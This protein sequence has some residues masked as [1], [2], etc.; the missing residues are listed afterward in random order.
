MR[1]LEFTRRTDAT[2]HWLKRSIDV[3]N[4]NGSSAYYSLLFRPWRGGWEKAYPE[5][6]GYLIETLLDYEQVSRLP[7]LREYA[8]RC[9]HWLTQ[10]QMESGAMPGGV[11]GSASPSIFNTGQILFGLV[12]A[13]EVTGELV[14]YQ[15]FEKAVRWMCHS[16]EPD[17]SWKTGAYLK[18]YTPSYYTRAVWGVL[19]ANRHLQ[20]SETTDAMLKA[21]NYYQAQITAQ[22]SVHNWGF[23]PGEAAFTH[24][25]AYTIRGFLESAL[26]L[27]NAP[28][29][30]T[31]VQL[32]S[33]VAAVY[34]REGRLAGSYDERWKG[35]Y[36]F[37]CLTGNAQMSIVLARL[38]AETG[39]VYFK[40]I[41][42]RI[43][44]DIKACQRRA[45]VFPNI[46]GAI[47]GSKPY[48]GKYFPFRYPN[49]AAKFYL[50]AY[51]INQS[52]VFR[53]NV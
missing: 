38:F 10:Q 48:W 13:W 51:L 21:L 8:I 42:Q 53:N 19:Y 33:Q 6:T 22:Q 31:A 46:H 30:E 39:R 44:E 37:T 34:E 41:S 3:C 1:D 15:T 7:W 14:F 5:T 35:D 27:K 20:Q 47:P 16:L 28:L 18:D 17:G 49:W 25:I 4:G 23:R 40:D 36:R 32:G 12:R 24:T 45:A 50:D 29:L 2:L 43:F 26:L 52:S 9:A 11:A